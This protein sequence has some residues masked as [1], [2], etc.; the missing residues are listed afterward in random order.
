NWRRWMDA[1]ARGVWL[2]KIPLLLIAAAAGVVAFLAKQETGAVY[3]LVKHG[4]I[5]RIGFSCYALVF[6]LWKTIIPIGLSP[7]YQVSPRPDPWDWPFVLSEVIVLA[8]TVGL[9]L[10]KKRHPAL[11]ACWACYAVLLVP[12]LGIVSFGPQI[13][14]DRYSYVSCLGWALLAG[15]GLINLSEPS[16]HFARHRTA[17][18]AIGLSAFVFIAL[19]FLS[20]QQSQ[21]WHDSDRL[22]R[23]VLAIN[24]ASSY[25]YHNLGSEQQ[26][27]GNIDTAIEFYR[28]AVE[29]DPEFARAHHN[30]GDVYGSHGDFELAL[31]SYRKAIAIDPRSI[32]TYHNLAN[33]LARL[34]K[35]DE[36]LKEFNKALQIKPNDATLHNDLGNLMVERGDLD[37]ALSHFQKSAELDPTASL[38]WF[39]LGNLMV[40]LNRLD[41]A[42]AYFRHALKIDPDYAEAHNNLGRLLA[43]QGKLDEAVDH[44]REAVRINPRFAGAHESL[45]Q[46]LTEQGKKEEAFRQYQ[47]AR[48][49]LQS[50]AAPGNNR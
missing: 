23:R 50:P 33:L 2:E 43:A 16:R 44:F 6:Y 22:W 28:K 13:V 12:V 7:L 38:P 24:P 46:A 20:W 37:S 25:A 42:V 47:I 48:R 17:A 26:L 41:Q 45:I 3:S 49:I 36:A 35:T 32:D 34:G 21:V 15:A 4:W 30:L 9:L 40:R 31:Q 39:N 11:L 18:P 14:A 19:A 1:G 5:L 8:I 10:L 29:L 27:K